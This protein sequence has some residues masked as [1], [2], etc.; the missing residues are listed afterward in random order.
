MNIAKTLSRPIKVAALAACRE[1]VS[2]SQQRQKE[3]PDVRSAII[4]SF[5]A[6]HISYLWSCVV[7]TKL[8]GGMYE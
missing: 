4:L 3:M 8:K 5:L 6:S 2:I 7:K 1:R